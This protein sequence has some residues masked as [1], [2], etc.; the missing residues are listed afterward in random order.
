MSHF[1]K[2][3]PH[4]PLLFPFHSCLVH[5]ISN[6]SIK[7]T[8]F[9]LSTIVRIN[10]QY[11]TQE[12]CIFLLCSFWRKQNVQKSQGICFSVF[13]SPGVRDVD[14]QPLTSLRQLGQ[15]NQDTI[16]HLRR[17]NDFLLPDDFYWEMCPWTE[18]YIR[19]NV[20]VAFF[21]FFFFRMNEYS[22]NL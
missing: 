22:C 17:L 3:A 14:V 7:N 18:N 5:G 12:R 16:W 20:Y 15:E 6:V 8:R 4:V 1:N 21:F 9:S 11:N 13:F 10:V 19:E 2:L